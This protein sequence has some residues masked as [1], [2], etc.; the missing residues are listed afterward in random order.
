MKDGRAA[1]DRV[2]SEPRQKTL[3]AVS[4]AG[5]EVGAESVASDIFHSLLVGDRR[6][7]TRYKIFAEGLVKEDKV[8]EAPA[9]S[10]HWFLKGGKGGLVARCGASF[11]LARRAR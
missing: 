5:S 2:E 7:R 6:N 1:E 9:H 11:E 10:R 4:A 8:C 3:E